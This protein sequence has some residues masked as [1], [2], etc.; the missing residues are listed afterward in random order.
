MLFFSS[1]LKAF[2]ENST[3]NKKVFNETLLN[4]FPINRS[5]T[6]LIDVEQVQPGE[7][8]LIDLD[9]K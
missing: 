8:I 1:E 5:E 7:L 4:G 9:M 3:L 2:H 6:L